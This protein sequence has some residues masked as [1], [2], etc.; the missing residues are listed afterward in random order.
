MVSAMVDSAMVVRALEP[1]EIAATAALLSKAMD[2]DP[3]YRFLFPR[4]GDRPAGLQDFFARHLRTHLPYRCTYVGVMGPAVVATVT[5]RPP[6]GV[7]ISVWT[8]IRRGLFPFALAHGH[9]AVQ[10][11]LTLKSTYDAIEARLARGEP[12]WLVHMMAVDPS[13]QGKGLG[14]HLLDR[15]LETTVGT[16]AADGAPPAVLTTHKQ[17]NVVFYQRAGFAV[18]GV[19]DVSLRGDP[20]YSAW[21]MRR[22]ART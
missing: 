13:R 14:S 22:R 4:E 6:G 12:H 20:S 19:E 10:R 3:A 15:V 5:M 9:R 16:R 7:P 1:A 18:D 2:D 8:M 21:S 11:M 17:R